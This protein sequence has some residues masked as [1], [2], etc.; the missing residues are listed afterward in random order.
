MLIWFFAIVGYVSLTNGQKINVSVRDDIVRQLH[1]GEFI[2][3]RNI[4]FQFNAVNKAFYDN[5]NPNQKFDWNTYQK[6]ERI[7]K[8]GHVAHIYFRP[9]RSFEGTVAVVF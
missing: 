3:E 6:C 1:L 5:L 4:L 9:N 7:N 8:R 2:D